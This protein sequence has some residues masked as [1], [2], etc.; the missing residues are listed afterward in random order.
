MFSRGANTIRALFHATKAGASS[1][2]TEYLQR[3]GTSAREI[4]FVLVTNTKH[5][6]QVH[7]IPILA[8][9]PGATYRFRYR[10]SYLDEPESIK[11]R[12]N[13]RGLLVL[14]DLQR[15]K[16]IPLRTCRLFRIEPY[17][18]YVFFEIEFL[19]FVSYSRTEGA[20]LD[21]LGADTEAGLRLQAERERYSGIIE[22]IVKKRGLTNEP[23][24]DLKKVMLEVPQGEASGVSLYPGENI[25]DTVEPWARIVT[26]LGG[27]AAYSRACFFHVAAIRDLKG[28]G[29]RRFRTKWRKGIRL[30]AGMDYAMSVV[31]LMGTKDVPPL[32]GFDI[33]LQHL[34]R[35]IVPL[36]QKERVDGPYDKL[37]YFFC[38]R[39]QESSRSQSLI[40]VQSEQKL[41]GAD[42][43]EAITSIPPATIHLQ[44]RWTWWKLFRRFFVSPTL[45]AGGVVVWFLAEKLSKVTENLV[46]PDNF[47]LVAVLLLAAA[48]QNLA[49]FAGALKPQGGSKA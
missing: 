26:I 25:G 21:Q 18:D 43:S 45:F 23:A 31:Q 41:A 24:K 29:V 16:F 1:F 30:H 37:E 33:A 34:E 20:Y 32:P 9:P 13:E 14:R 35:D 6:Y 48:I 8:L 7:N 36:R 38:A 28:R 42:A 3:L 27:L 15:A 49:V 40:V 10:A 44:L 5:P 2:R 12:E 46:T 47:K 17:G 39:E 19:S 11:N 4:R 22:G